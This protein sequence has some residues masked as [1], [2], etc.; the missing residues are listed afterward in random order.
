MDYVVQHNMKLTA[1]NAY[2]SRKHLPI[3]NE[4]MSVKAKNATSYYSQQQYYPYIHLFFHIALNGKLMM[5]SGKGKKLHLTVTERWNT[6]KH[7]TDTEKY[8]FLLET[9]WVDVSW[10]RLLN[11]HNINIHHILPDV[12]EKLMDHTRIRARFTS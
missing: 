7:L 2:I 9:F 4:Q 8:F 5:K 6:F 12:L 1:K 11:R 3:I 10:A